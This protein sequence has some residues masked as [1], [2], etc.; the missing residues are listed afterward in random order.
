MRRQLI[1]PRLAEL[2]ADQLRER[3]LDG[4][5]TEGALL[6]KQEHLLAEFGVSGPSLRG[7]LRILETEGLLSVRRGSQGGAVV[8]E[9]RV[10]TAAYI[11]S[12]TLER[13]RV[14]L[15]EV[16]DA[17]G[18]LE[19]LCAGL[20]A[21]RE[22]RLDAVVPALEVA[23]RGTE[24][25]LNDPVRFAECARRFHEQIVELSGHETMT[26][27]V[28]AVER[29]WSSQLVDSDADRSMVYL[30]TRSERE[31]ALQRHRALVAAIRFGDSAT[32]SELLRQHFL[33]SLATHPVPNDETVRARRPT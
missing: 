21:D 19:P 17:I 10:E 9:F 33:T 8:R 5:F 12:L 30:S 27:L 29:V 25:A 26:L 32:A 24:E 2:V 20:C 18:R 13:K 16:V 7:A 11:L 31:A 6:P 1:Q 3:I 14:P 22:D 4:E 15:V 28:G 23:A